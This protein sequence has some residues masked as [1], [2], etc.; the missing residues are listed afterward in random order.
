VTEVEAGH[1]DAGH[2]AKG[3]DELKICTYYDRKQLTR[4][5]QIL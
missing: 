1:T 4:K 3:N 2:L 5:E